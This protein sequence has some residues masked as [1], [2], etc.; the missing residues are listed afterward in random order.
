M[1]VQLSSERFGD[2]I[3]LYSILRTGERRRVA[4]V[5][6]TDHGVTSDWTIVAWFVNEPEALL[7]CSTLGLHVTT[8][9]DPTH[10]PTHGTNLAT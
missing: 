7:F 5:R 1:K 10:T 2:R 4:L 9:D 3:A 8:H 6:S